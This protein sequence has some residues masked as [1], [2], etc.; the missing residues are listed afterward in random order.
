MSRNSLL[1]RKIAKKYEEKYGKR[2]MKCGR[3][4]DESNPVDINGICFTCNELK[5]SQKGY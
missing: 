4:I 1:E 5:H 3:L 2:C